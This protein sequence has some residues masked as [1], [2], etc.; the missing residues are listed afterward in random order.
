MQATVE[1]YFQSIHS[2]GWEEFVGDDIVFIR[3]NL[4]NRLDGKDAYLK[5][6]GTF[7]GTTTGVEIE[8]LFTDGDKTSVLARYA[9]QA[10]D[11]RTSTCDVAEFL[12][13]TNGKLTYSAIFFD[14]QALRDF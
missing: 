6:A 5:G 4:D 7:F 2:G 11:G 12:Q 3:N 13:F 8:Q 9:V 1:K 10:P 14:A